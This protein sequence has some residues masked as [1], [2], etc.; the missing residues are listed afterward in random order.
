MLSFHKMAAIV[1][2]SLCISI[3]IN[4]FLVP[5]HVLDGGIIGIALIINYVFGTKVGLVMFLCSTPIFALAWLYY[6]EMFYNSVRGLLFSS[7][8]IDLLETFPNPFLIY[9]K[10]S[11][12]ASSLLG[13]VIVGTGIG[14]MLRYKTSTGGTDLLAQFLSKKIHINV[15]I[16]IFIFDGII[17]CF[18]GLLLSADS[19][20]LSLITITAGG[21][22]TS[23]CTLESLKD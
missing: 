15:S 9:V 17:I 22:M 21:L 10:L 8:M 7:F 1:L 14:V 12:F 6:R 4:F 18:G 3:G 13:G 19:F 5:N 23:L 11:P 20:L 16:L 2:G